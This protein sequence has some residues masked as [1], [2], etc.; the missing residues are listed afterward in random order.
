MHLGNARTALLVWLDARARGG[1]VLLRI[2]DL[3]RD[4]CRP[5]FAAAI[6]DDLR[7]LGL[8]W[9][10]E[11][12]PQSV[13]DA[14][15]QEAVLRL[16]RDGLTY[17]CFCTRREV[18]VASAPHG[19]ADPA[20]CP[21]RCRDLTAAEQEAL[22]RE[23]R[24]AALRVRMPAGSVT[25]ADRVHGAVPVAIGGDPVIRRSDGLH[26]YQLAVVVD[27]AADGV[28]DVLRGDDL[29]PSSG[30]QLTLAGMLGLEPVRYA[31]VPLVLGPDGARLAKR[32]G[33]VTLAELRDAGT[34]ARGLVGRL[35]A[36][37]RLGHGSPISPR[38]LIGG[39]DIARIP[40][41]PWRMAETVSADGPDGK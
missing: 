5:E 19:E 13:R 8:D 23:G 20:P 10:A 27:D 26:A 35:A 37:C 11:T 15:Y 40:R 31:H 12:A 36:S 1:R 2:E 18:A 30:S 28:T 21:R 38:E 6:R 25:I 32:H 16:E 22:R 33:A 14:A 7:W 34:T 4:R 24:R 39:F 41:D 17:E 9:D 29:L 3:D